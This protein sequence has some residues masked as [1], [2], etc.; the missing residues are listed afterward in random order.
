MKMI[1]RTLYLYSPHEKLAKKI[2]FHE[3]INVITSSQENGTDRGKSV[4]MRSLYHA[5]GAEALFEQK[6][7]VKNKVFVLCFSIDDDMYYIY[8]SC[9]LY[10]VFDEK[11]KLLFSAVTSRE[12]SQYLKSILH[13][14]VMLPSRHTEKLEITPPVYNYLPFFLDQDHYDG[15]QFTSF[16][17]LGQYVNF[18]EFVL[19]YHFG[20]YDEQYFSLTQRKEKLSEEIDEI[21]KHLNILWGMIEDIDR[22]LE[23]G[24]YAGDI[25]ALNLSVAQY[26]SEYSAIAQ[27]LNSCK[28]KLVELR[29]AL[30][31]LETL[32]KETHEFGNKTEKEIRQLKKHI[33]PEC[34]SQITDTIVLKS[35]RYNIAEDVIIVKN[36]LQVSIQKLIAD[37]ASEEQKYQELLLRMREYEK[38][39][40]INTAQVSDILRHKGL[41]ELRDSILSERAQNH[42]V[43][44]KLI[45]EQE[46]IKKKLGSYSDR[47]KT[48]LERYYE[49][50]IQGKTRFGL[51]E[52]DPEKFRSLSTN[53]VASGSNR[54][55]ATVI[56]YFTIIQLRNEFNPT[57]IQFPIVFDSPKN[58]EMDSQKEGA[59]LEYLIKNAELSAQFIVSGLGYNSDEFKRL[60]EESM[61]IIVLDNDKYHLL[62]PDDYVLY[63]PLMEELCDAEM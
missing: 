11:K 25:E 37:I 33:C 21:E 55:I 46:E 44:D 32:L 39:L 62:V 40:E 26:R 1:F 8:R 38:K 61:N 2:D 54:N 13:F 29:N 51:D 36:D 10:K 16:G 35:K 43:Q 27:D 57:A 63:S 50:L 49:L 52:I 59:L 42:N 5:L 56:W 14:A 19:Y 45:D 3:G 34:G 30:F 23:V 24:A 17:R 4:I 48:L 47:K 12:L 41:C 9:D 7:D 6:W 60:T 22:K 53:F 18:K 20:V 58:V 28:M 31:D 15:S